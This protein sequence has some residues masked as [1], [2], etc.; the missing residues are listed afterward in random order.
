MA[1][2]RSAMDARGEG[3]KLSGTAKE[4]HGCL[5]EGE[6]LQVGQVSGDLGQVGVAE[7]LRK[8]VSKVT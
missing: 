3:E 6:K 5:G 7:V 8:V 4:C 2:Q 1:L